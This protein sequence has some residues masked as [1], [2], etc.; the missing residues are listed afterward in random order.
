MLE[1]FTSQSCS[2]CPAA[3][4]L[5]SQLG[6]DGTLPYVVIPLAYHVDYWNRTGWRDPFAKKQW[7]ARQEAYA[8]TLRTRQI[9]TPQA[10][11][12]GRMEAIG[13]DETRLREEIRNAQLT[14][15]AGRVTLSIAR[16]MAGDLALRVRVTAELTRKLNAKAVQVVVALFE[17]DLTT[18][19]A[20]GE[21]RGQTLTND[22]VVRQLVQ[23]FSLS[24]PFIEQEGLAVFDLDPRWRTDALGVAAFLQDPATLAIYGATVR[25]VGGA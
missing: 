9:Y 11:I 12:N 21:N 16:P 4:R 23:V 15:P 22:F 18:E 17:N 2:S 7:T 24:K 14:P 3:D 1:L 19:V 5:V 8:K 25:S 6:R 13:S 10:I 20:D